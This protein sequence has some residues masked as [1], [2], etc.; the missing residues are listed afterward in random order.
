MSQRNLRFS[1]FC[2]KPHLEML[3]VHFCITHEKLIAEEKT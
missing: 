2:D 3:S 1:V